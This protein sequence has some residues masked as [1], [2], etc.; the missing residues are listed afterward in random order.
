MKTILLL[1]VTI[2]FALVLD[3]FFASLGGTIVPSLAVAVICF[4]FWRLTLVERLFLAFV[5]G[6]LLDVI[7]FLPMGAHALILVCMA[8]V[9][10]LMKSFFSNN[11]SR[12]VIVI[13][14]VILMIVFRLLV[15]PVSLLITFSQSFL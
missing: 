9:C 7:G 6:L 14:V 4:W 11:E 12:V 15:T 3:V 8:Y 5:F 13:N 10:E 2:Y 1:I